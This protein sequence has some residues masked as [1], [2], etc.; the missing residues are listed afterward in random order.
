MATKRA[1]G[2]GR[3]K[4]D[5]RDK[6][7]IPVTVLASLNELEAMGGKE[8]AHVIVSQAYRKELSRKLK[9]KKDL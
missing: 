9:N 5:P 3:K 2:A 7:N 1:P 8:Y 6:K 4:L